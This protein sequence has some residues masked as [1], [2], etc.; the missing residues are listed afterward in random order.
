MFACG[1][2]QTPNETTVDL[3][4]TYAEEFITN[5]VVQAQRRSSRHGSNNL[6]LADI[7]HTIRHDEVKFLRLPY[8]IT[9]HQELS[10]TEKAMNVNN[11]HCDDEVRKNLKFS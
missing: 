1:D 7:L 11:K 4:E 2:D 3:L 9:M 8:I 5:L 10:K 6:R